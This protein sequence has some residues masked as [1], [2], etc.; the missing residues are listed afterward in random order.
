[1]PC[2]A[3][4][5]MGGLTLVVISAVAAEVRSHGSAPLHPVSPAGIGPVRPPNI[6]S[7]HGSE[8]SYSAPP[9]NASACS[10]C[11]QGMRLY[12]A[13]YPYDTGE[14]RHT[15]VGHGHPDECAKWCVAIKAP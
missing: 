3:S 15:T 7:K 13:L 14:T 6:T 5:G 4:R 9:P 11:S 2:G 1:M 10:M 8:L 12:W